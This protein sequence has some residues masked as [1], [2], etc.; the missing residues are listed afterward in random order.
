MEKA[1]QD[2]IEGKQTSK[3]AVE[4]AQREAMQILQTMGSLG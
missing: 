1:L 2:V 3:N 4:Q